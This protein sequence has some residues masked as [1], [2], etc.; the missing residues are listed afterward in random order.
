MKRLKI[1]ILFYLLSPLI[2]FGQTID[3]DIVDG[4]TMGNPVLI[5]THLEEIVELIL[6]EVEGSYSKDAAGFKLNAFF[7]SFSPTEFEIVHQGQSPSGA[8][9]RIGELTTEAVLFRVYLLFSEIRENKIIEIR[10]ERNE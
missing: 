6:P 3:Q 7:T 9:Y 4:F 5:T 1:T 10:I 8:S 2:S